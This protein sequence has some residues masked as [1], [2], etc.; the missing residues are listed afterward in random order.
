MSR[1]GRGGARRAA[2]MAL[3]LAAPGAC[4]PLPHPFA[5]DRPP[6]ALLEIRDSPGVA[7]APLVGVPPATVQ[8]LG[9]ATA[10][11]LLKDDIPASDKTANLDSYRLYGRLAQSQTKDGVSTVT[12]LWRLY[13]AKGRTLGEQS[14][15]LAGQTGDWEA[16]KDAPVEKLATLSA[17][18]L[19][20]MLEDKAPAAA[21]AP[22]PEKRLKV[23]VD[24]VNGAPGDGA[25]ALKAAMQ[26]VLT[27]Q[28]LAVVEAKAKPDLL[29]EAD[30]AVSP[31]KLGQQ[32]VKIVWHVRR[33]DGGEIGTVGQENDVPPGT[34]DGTWGDIAYSVAV[35]AGPGLMQLVERGAQAVHSAANPS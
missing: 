32:H 5:D 26:A 27:Q 19:A 20:P 29:V 35:A 33:A 11:A 15:K 16:G 10:K 21:A 9:A 28:D 12:A 6:A 34:L 30:I 13:N 24:K 4:Q 7:I 23:A 17:D 2:I 1:H 8:K 3:A 25:A 18:A 31:A 22:A 14:V